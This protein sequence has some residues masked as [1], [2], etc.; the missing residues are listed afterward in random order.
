[1]LNK[2]ICFLLVFCLNIGVLT[3]E[4]GASEITVSADSA[5]VMIAE[6]GQVVFSKN[7]NEQRGI[8]STTKIMSSIIALES[9]KLY[10]NVT[11]E[12]E[13]VSVEGTALGL[14]A[15][16]KI[17]LYELVKGMLLSSGNDSANVTATF[18]GGNIDG[19]SRLMNNKAAKIGMKSTSFKNPS[20]LTQEGHYSTAYDMALLGCYAVKN[21]LFCE[22]CS[23]VSDTVFFGNPPYERTI[24]NHNSFLSMYDGAFGIKT[25]FTKASGRCLV[26]A[27]KKGDVTLVAVT[28]NA[29]D[30]WNDHKRMYDYAFSVIKFFTPCI[31]VSC[32]NAVGGEK[33]RISVK[34]SS[35]LSIPYAFN[36]PEY[37]IEVFVPPFL[38]CPVKKG[39]YIGFVRVSYFG[40]FNKK[41][42]IVSGEKNKYI[43]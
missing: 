36:K 41:H 40:F 27:V 6:T 20:G 8:A 37:K 24:Y 13:D 3:F 2:A 42:Y 29:P 9:G 16:D 12:Y 19:F 28:L 21:S 22:I 34:I 17:S 23:S 31:N 10:E 39:D 1:M 14:K 25:G 18:L 35:E 30:D 15:G 26:T 5:V 43:K 33:Q 32:I 7:M 11:A 38:Y 4:A